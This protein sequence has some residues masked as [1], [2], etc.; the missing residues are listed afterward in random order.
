MSAGADERVRGAKD[1]LLNS[2]MYYRQALQQKGCTDIN[3]E[4]AT[5]V[6]KAM[7]LTQPQTD[8]IEDSKKPNA[9]EILDNAEIILKTM[10][11]KDK[12]DKE[13]VSLI[14]KGF[15]SLKGLISSESGNRES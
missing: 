5:E 4:I 8:F 2:L 13:G 12:V 15:K 9:K 14:I 10:V 3:K 6:G 7:L 1:A 11:F